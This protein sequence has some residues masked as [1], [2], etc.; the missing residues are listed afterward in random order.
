MRKPD[1]GQES[2]GVKGARRVMEDGE[3]L[4]VSFAIRLLFLHCTCICTACT[5]AAPTHP[6]HY[7]IALDSRSEARYICRQGRG[8]A[9]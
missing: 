1:R 3:E 9:I 5:L 8:L 6:L 2:K 4:S 7:T